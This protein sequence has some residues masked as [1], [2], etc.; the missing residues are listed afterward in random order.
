MTARINL[1]DDRFSNTSNTSL[2]ITWFISWEMREREEIVGGTNY[3][4]LIR[5]AHEEP[6]GDA[7]GGTWN[8]L[9]S[10]MGDDVAGRGMRTRWVVR[11]DNAMRIR[12]IFPDSRDG[13]RFH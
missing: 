9:L 7:L 6:S 4:C 5:I 8:G 2:R 1:S 13:N 11:L 12:G 3:E 10:A